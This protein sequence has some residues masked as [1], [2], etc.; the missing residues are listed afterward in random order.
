MNYLC[1]W[2]VTG[3]EM[4]QSTSIK[5]WKERAI[6]LAEKSIHEKVVNEIV[7]RAKG[8]KVGGPSY[9]EAETGPLI[10]ASHLNKI[11]RAHV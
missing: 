2:Y 6:E 3:K 7:R 9:A 1:N 11:G 8:I 4:D 5:A 10:S